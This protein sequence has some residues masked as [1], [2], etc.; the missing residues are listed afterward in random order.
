MWCSLRCLGDEDDDIYDDN[1]PQMES[2]AIKHQG[3]VNRVRVS[4]SMKTKQVCTL[5]KNWLCAQ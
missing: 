1:E 4:P 3:G 2:V 5:V